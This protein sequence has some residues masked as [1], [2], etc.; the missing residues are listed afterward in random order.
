MNKDSIQFTET[1]LAE[2]LDAYTDPTHPEY[3]PKF[4][5]KIKA[6]RPDWFPTEVI[7]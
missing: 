6:I 1:E 7:H 2:A 5:A 4:T 3:D